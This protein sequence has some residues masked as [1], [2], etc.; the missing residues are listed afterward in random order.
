M[1]L[2]QGWSCS[3]NHDG[4][5]LEL[6]LELNFSLH[7]LPC[8]QATRVPDAV[9]SRGH[10]SIAETESSDTLNNLAKVEP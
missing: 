2:Q 7:L 9:R 4:N 5:M 1:N 10:A 6:A 3:T 8:T